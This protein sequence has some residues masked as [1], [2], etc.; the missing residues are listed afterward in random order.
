MRQPALVVV[1][2]ATASMAMV[3]APATAQDV[4]EFSAEAL[5][6]FAE[7]AKNYQAG[8]YVA[9]IPQYTKAFELDGSFFV[10]LFQ[11]AL[12]HSNLGNI[13]TRDSLLAIVDA[14]RDRLSEY[15]RHRLDTQLASAAGNPDGALEAARKAAAVGPGT[16][17][18]YQVAYWALRR[19]RPQEAKDALVSLDPEREPMKGW[20]AYWSHLAWAHHLLGEH[21]AELTVAQRYRELYADRFAP[22]TAEAQVLAATGQ[23]D[24]LEAVIAEAKSMTTAAAELAAHGHPDAAKDL[25]NR[26]ADWYQQQPADQIRSVAHRNWHTFTLIAAGRWNAAE[27]VCQSLLDDV[28]ANGWFHAMDGYAAARKGDRARAMS[29]L[30]WLEGQDETAGFQA[31][32]HAAL[33]DKARALELLAES[34]ESGA[35]FTMWSHRD[36]LLFPLLG[37][38]PAFAEITRPKG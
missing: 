5:A 15:Y 34:F 35:S 36:L 22:L 17:G 21:E 14:S 18:V 38:D 24:G 30:E 27:P 9:A 6:A 2:L 7:G 13:A 32:V 26:A 29:Q 10:A 23:M 12:C 11:A 4:P 20:T 3:P 31:V 8:R 1:A 33:G 25:Y 16:K 28:P 19:N 37:D